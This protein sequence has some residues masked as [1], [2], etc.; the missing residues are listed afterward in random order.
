MTT[1]L[2]HGLAILASFWVGVLANHL[3]DAWRRY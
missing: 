2:L 3:Y 1:A